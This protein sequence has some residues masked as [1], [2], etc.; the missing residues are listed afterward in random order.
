MGWFQWFERDV[1]S[2]I[3]PAYS[4]ARSS[5]FE[6]C[7]GVGGDVGVRRRYRFRIRL[8][9]L[10]AGDS[11][12]SLTVSSSF[13]TGLCA[14]A[15]SVRSMLDIC[16]KVLVVLRGFV[17]LL[18]DHGTRA[19]ETRFDEWWEILTLDERRWRV[20]RRRVDV[21]ARFSRVGLSDRLQDKVNA[22]Y[23]HPTLIATML[24]RFSNN[25]CKA[26]RSY[27]GKS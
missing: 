16:L 1:V 24:G 3:S 25:G 11:F 14:F 5:L 23:N 27:V 10:T 2:V 13:P 7:C 19:S 6:A 8:V 17:E 9:T 20:E 26:C 18:Q 4:L 15:V 21:L 22:Y 12:L